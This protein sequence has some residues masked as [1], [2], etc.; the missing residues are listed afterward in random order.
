MQQSLSKG[1]KIVTIGGLHGE[2]D[3]IDE[4]KVVIKTSENNRLTFDRRAIRELAD[5]G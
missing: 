4:S 3:S 2:I 1:D 5:K